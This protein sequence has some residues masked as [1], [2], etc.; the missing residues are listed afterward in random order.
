MVVYRLPRMMEREWRA[1]CAE[2]AGEDAIPGHH[3]G[4]TAT[5][6]AT[7]GRFNLAFPASH[8]PACNAP[9]RLWQNIP[10]LSWLL[11]RGRCAACSARIGLRYPLIELATGAASAV[12]AWRLGFGA[13]ACAG[14]LATWTLVALATI[15]IE[16][17]L[18]PDRL[19]LPLLWG[20]LLLSVGGVF[21]DPASAI[22]GAAAG[23]GSLWLIYAGYRLLTGKEGMG[24]GDFKLL[25]ACGAWFGWQALPL[26][27]LLAS[28]V[29][30]VIGIALLVTSGR[31]V[32]PFGPFLAAGM[33][34]FML[35]SAPLASTYHRLLGMPA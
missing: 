15:D 22:I 27:V 24:H 6:P 26:V 3:P 29:G 34:V 10:V 1:Q 5:A 13:A 14:L 30:S 23:Y 31:R 32:L 17:Y 12:V 28:L 33:W 16:H 25:A 19:T 20:G 11:L 21:T 18:L 2:L 9:I 35:W 8:C 4:E 7:T